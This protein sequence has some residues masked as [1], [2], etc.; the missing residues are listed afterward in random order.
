MLNDDV[1]MKE[2]PEERK[3]KRSN[4][5]GMRGMGNGGKGKKRLAACFDDNNNNVTHK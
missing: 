2:E 3:E 4:C 5:L 1:K